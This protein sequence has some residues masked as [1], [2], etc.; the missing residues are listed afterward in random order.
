MEKGF[1]LIELLTVLAIISILSSVSFA[2]YREGEKEF[3]LLRSAHKLAQDIRRAQE[4]AMGARECCDGKIPA[5]Y[6]I[7]LKKNDD[8]YLLYADTNPPKGN[9]NYDNDEEIEKIFFEKGIYIKNLS[10]SNVSINFK[11]PE[12]KVK[13][14]GD[15]DELEIVI[16]LKDRPE[17]EKKIK[18]NR[19]GLVFVE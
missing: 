13:I 11:P 9:E 17:K 7:H 19:A 14:S 18:V 8:F 10:P 1:T 15:A 6:G 3:A 16:S 12:P 2:Y 5:G 4:M